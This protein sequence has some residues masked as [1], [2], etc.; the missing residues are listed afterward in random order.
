MNNIGARIRYYRTL[1]NLTQVELGEKLGLSHAAISH[2]ETGR[3]L[4]N[5][6]DIKRLSKIF[7]IPAQELLDNLTTE[8]NVE[9]NIIPT[10]PTKLDK[11]SINR[12]L[13]Q[14]S[15]NIVHNLNKILLPKKEDVIHVSITKFSK[16]NQ[17]PDHNISTF[18]SDHIAK[19]ERE[20]KRQQHI[21]EGNY[22]RI[23]VL[24]TKLNNY[25][26]NA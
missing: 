1:H 18:Y 22:K 14:E 8:N 5:L 7:S 6:F 25:M 11:A 15:K 2:F 3:T 23:S 9:K 24:E 19:L 10:Q 13:K 4:P 21:I 12:N 16:N 17:I 26:H 20:I